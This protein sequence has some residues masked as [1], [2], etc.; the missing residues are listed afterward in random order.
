MMISR[1]NYLNICFPFISHIVPIQMASIE[2]HRINGRWSGNKERQGW[3]KQ[4]LQPILIDKFEIYILC[5][6]FRR[7]WNNE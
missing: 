1:Q 6:Y 7:I 5:L 4:Y 2:L 3:A